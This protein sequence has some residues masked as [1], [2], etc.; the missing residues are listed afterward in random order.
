ML[1]QVI[2]YIMKRRT[3]LFASTKCA[4]SVIRDYEKANDDWKR[5]ALWEEDKCPE[6]L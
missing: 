1:C 5:I 6:G 4:T 3:L 2:V